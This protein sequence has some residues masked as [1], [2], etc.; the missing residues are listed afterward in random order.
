MKINYKQTVK[1]NTVVEADDGTQY[2][3]AYTTSNENIVSVDVDGNVKGIKRGHEI[4]TCT[5]TD[6]YG[7]Q[8]QD[9]CL[10]TV[11]YS[12]WQWLIKILLFGWIWY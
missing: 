4:V 12:P 3:I 7:N 6:I 11:K 10:V 1:L 9:T 5:V 2:E 8:R